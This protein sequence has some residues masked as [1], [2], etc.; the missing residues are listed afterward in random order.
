MKITLEST[1]RIVQ[2]KST[3]HGGTVPGRVWQGTTE[4]GIPVA[5]VITSL[6]VERTQDQSEFQAQFQEH[7]APQG[8]AVEAFPLR[9]II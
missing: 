1:E 9:F 7:A 6:A 2:L 4:S 8:Y 5:V 3:T